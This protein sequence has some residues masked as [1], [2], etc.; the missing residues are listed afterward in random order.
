MSIQADINDAIDTSVEALNAIVP[1]WLERMP[2]NLRQLDVLNAEACPLFYV[3]GD[4]WTGMLALDNA[5][6]ES[7]RL[8]FTSLWEWDDLSWHDR[9]DARDQLRVAW[10]TRIAELRD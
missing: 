7:S 1:D 3:F 8:A 9:D 6:F 4:F 2:A 5:G 10:R